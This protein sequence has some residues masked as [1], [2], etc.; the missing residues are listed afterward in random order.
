MRAVSASALCGDVAPKLSAVAR[1]PSI[2]FSGSRAFCDRFRWRRWLKHKILRSPP[3]TQIGR[4]STENRGNW[5][6]ALPGQ[7]AVNL[8]T[9]CRK[10]RTILVRERE[11]HEDLGFGLGGVLCAASSDIS[12]IHDVGSP[13]TPV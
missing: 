5:P 12:R 2:I 3:G 6:A 9:D 1:R 11:H 7:Y 4:V 13:Q 10:G 8:P